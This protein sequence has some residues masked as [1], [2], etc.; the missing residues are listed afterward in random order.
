MGEMLNQIEKKTEKKRKKNEE[1]I[2]KRGETKLYELNFR[3]YTYLIRNLRDR[4]WFVWK[5][6]QI[7]KDLTRFE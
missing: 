6:Y 5:V 7:M 2:L 1:T 3:A 4:S